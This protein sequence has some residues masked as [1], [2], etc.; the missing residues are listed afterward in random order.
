MQKLESIKTGGE[1]MKMVCEDCEKIFDAEQMTLNTDSE[2]HLHMRCS[3][4][5]EKKTKRNALIKEHGLWWAIFS[6]EGNRQL[7][8]LEPGD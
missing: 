8:E 6:K 4:C 3:D 7:K 2:G 5:Y 1:Y